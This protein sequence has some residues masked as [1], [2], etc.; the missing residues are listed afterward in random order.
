VNVYWLFLATAICSFFGY[1][2]AV[3]Y[4]LSGITGLI[5]ALSLCVTLGTNMW[6]LILAWLMQG[7]HLVTASGTVLT[8]ATLFAFVEKYKFIAIFKITTMLFPVSFASVSLPHVA[9]SLTPDEP[10]SAIFSL[11]DLTSSSSRGSRSQAPSAA[12]IDGSIPDRYYAKVAE[13]SVLYAVT[14]KGLVKSPLIIEEG[15][16]VRAG[17]EVAEATGKRWVNVMVPNSEGRFKR[18]SSA[19]GYIPLSC[20]S[21]K[22]ASPPK[23]VVR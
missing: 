17:N 3:H 19:I 22:R 8:I 12:S 16:W 15:T 13:R 23:S 9:T 10:G 6:R 14:D 5:I 4:R 18:R 7:D 1:R 11:A 21:E 20:L 2:L